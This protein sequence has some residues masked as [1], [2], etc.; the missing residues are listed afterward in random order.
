M[1]LDA[2]ICFEQI[3]ELD[4]ERGFPPG[5]S[6][7]KLTRSEKEEYAFATHIVSGLDR[8]YG[9]GYERGNWPEICWVLM[10]LH[11]CPGVGEVWYGE[12][13]GISRFG[14]KDVLRISEH[15]MLYGERPYRNPQG[16]RG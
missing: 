14:I 7:R 10:L 2:S 12:P 8:Y 15:F 16:D 6:I 1:G 4:F 11:A 3:G 9:E 5:I 13:G